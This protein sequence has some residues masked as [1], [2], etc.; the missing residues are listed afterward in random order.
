[1]TKI[2]KG[3]FVEVEYTGRVKEDNFVFDTT[4]EK[5]AKD[6]HI[7][8]PRAHYGPAVICV[9]ERQLLPG[10]DKALEGK[11]LGKEYVIDLSPEDGF[12]KK[13]AQ[14]LKLIPANAFKKEG[15]PLQI[16]MQVEVD[17]EAGIIRAVSGGRIVVDFNHPLSSKEL[18]YTIKPLKVITDDAEK[19]KALLS[20]LLGLDK[21]K[22]EV[23]VEHGK[24]VV[25]MLK[26][27]DVFQKELIKRIT[28]L[29]PS[30]KDVVFE[31]EAEQK[32]TEKQPLNTSKQ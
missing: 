13:S 10:V 8:N 7:H 19:I 20:L 6:N 24:A 29:V 27:P 17:G 25:K 21:S 26:L 23:K 12:G 31:V 30:V 15:I 5:V 11:E 4:S 3:D 18:I 9:G 2:S 1:M 22:M 32:K 14:L 28:E 16:G